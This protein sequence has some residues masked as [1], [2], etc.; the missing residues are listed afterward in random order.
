LGKKDKIPSP[1][2]DICKDK[3]G[4]CIACGRTDRD[5]DAWKAAESRDEKMRLL[6]DCAAQTQALGTH[7][8][9]EAEYRR[10]CRKK[11]VDCPL[12]SFDL[13]PA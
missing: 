11:G 9:W 2:V 12:D 13:V 8:F 10:K 1:C 4:I 6:A 5:K 7:A 3:R